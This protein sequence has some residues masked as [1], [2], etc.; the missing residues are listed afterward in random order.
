MSIVTR[1]WSVVVLG[2]AVGGVAHAQPAMPSVEKLEVF[3]NLHEIE[4]T[5]SNA[6]S[7]DPSTYRLRSEAG[8]WITATEVRPFA[9]MLESVV[10][11][12]V[13]EDGDEDLA[14]AHLGLD[15]L[16]SPDSRAIVI[17]YGDGA[18]VTARAPIGT[19]PES[20][21]SAPATNTKRR[22]LA[23]A[24][25]VAFDE[26]A[27]RA[28]FA[29]RRQVIVIGSGR[30][31]DEAKLRRVRIRASAENVGVLAILRESIEPDTKISLAIPQTTI[32]RGAEAVRQ[33]VGRVIERL[34]DRHRVTFHDVDHRLPWD[35]Q[36]HDLQVS[37][38][39]VDSFPEWTGLSKWE[40]DCDS[41][42]SGSQWWQVAVVAGIFV[43]GFAIWSRRA[44]V[45]A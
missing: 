14:T 42:V 4:V 26:L 33:Q 7:N 10:V 18:R 32:A 1:W 21:L 43:L 29:D 36:M 37:S 38:G 44:A 3:E 15:R 12:F 45:R 6:S 20:A 27:E 16:A 31:T 35:G 11:A 19:L 8:A 25:E 34:A 39:G 28:A 23:E 13:I 24:L 30:I 41:C 2:F 5:L 22:D 17:T 40:D 9:D